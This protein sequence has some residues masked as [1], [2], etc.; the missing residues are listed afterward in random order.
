MVALAAALKGCP[1]LTELSCSQ[2]GV[3]DSGLAA[4]LETARRLAS[5]RT[6]DAQEN[7]EV[8]GRAGLKAL[9]PGRSS[10]GALAARR[11]RSVERRR[12]WWLR[13]R[14]LVSRRRAASG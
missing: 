4:L 14:R 10:I 11:S 6:I 12:R 1:A 8:W 9:V 5:L 13:R 2:C 3:G 7:G